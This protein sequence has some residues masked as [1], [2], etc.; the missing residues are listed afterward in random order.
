MSVIPHFRKRATVSGRMT[1][2][3][4][5]LV[6]LT[7]VC[8]GF[9]AGLFGVGGGMVIVPALVAFLGMD[10]RRASA[11]SLMAIILTAG[12]GVSSYAIEGQVSWGASLF[13]ILGGLLGAQIGV[14]LV[15]RI[16]ERLLPWIFLAFVVCVVVAQRIHIPVRDALFI[17]DVPRA[18]GLIV[19]GVLSGIFSGLVGVG[20]GSIIVPGLELVVGVGD[21]LARGTSLLVMIPTALSGTW[22]NA[23]RGLLEVKVAVYIAATAIVFTPVGAWV[24]RSISPRVSGVLFSCFLVIVALVMLTKARVSR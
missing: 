10:Q 21:L 15:Y 11:V 9:L 14:R 19:V 6:L 13:L 22:A 18:L 17:L 12:A 16:P 24:A 8:A 3:R 4:V 23:R 7:G 20:G 5:A 1:P 2:L